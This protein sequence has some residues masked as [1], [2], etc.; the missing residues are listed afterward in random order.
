MRFIFILIITYWKKKMIQFASDKAF[1]PQEKQSSFYVFLMVCVH[2][3]YHIDGKIK[4]YDKEYHVKFLNLD[5]KFNME[6]LNDVINNLYYVKGL[7]TDKDK[8]DI[9]NAIDSLKYNISTD[10]NFKKAYNILYTLLHNW[11]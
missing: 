8:L 10:S 9:I 7:F 6:C 4:I 1:F 11:I 3:D 2:R 5:N